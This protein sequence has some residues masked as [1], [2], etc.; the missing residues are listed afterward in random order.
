MSSI[1]V[2]NL[3]KSFG[4]RRELTGINDVS[5][6]VEAGEMLV[7]VGP[8][9]CG[10][11][12][13]LQCLAG[14]QTPDAGVIR[15]ANQTTFDSERR[16]AVPT[17][18]RDIGLVFQNYALWP[19]LTGWG[20]IGF[21]LKSRKVPR[22]E[23]QAKIKKI[24]EIVDLDGELLDKRP[25]QLSGG[26][27]QR[28]ALAR[29]LVAEPQVVMFDEP[30]SNLDAALREQLRSEIRRL[31]KQVG[32]TGVYV[33]HDL[34]EA[35]M[36]GDSVL[37]MTDGEI[38]EHSRPQDLF[39]APHTSRIAHLVGYRHLSSITYREGRWKSND[40][41][42]RGRIDPGLDT[43]RAYELLTRPE[44]IAVTSD[45]EGPRLDGEL[46]VGG[47]VVSHVGYLGHEQEVIVEFD[48][49]SLRLAVPLDRS[50]QPGTPV[51]LGVQLT[52]VRAYER[53]SGAALQPN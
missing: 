39:N 26:Q 48:G 7:I 46:R 44:N 31:H 2:K 16:V 38:A 17:H 32:F 33:T 40:S 28:L 3:K 8:S 13:T 50:L 34:S 14:L 25:A 22:E 9:G 24:A 42:L 43:S 49:R 11:T 52:N 51:E 18:R 23:R 20:N 6:E 12:T 27:Q 47:G 29:A 19:H 10:K 21:P 53:T 4:S 45:S 41:I 37:A 35:M 15:F 5:F 1:T 36:L 30:L